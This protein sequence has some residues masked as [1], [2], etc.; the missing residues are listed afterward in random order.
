MWWASGINARV[1]NLE[2]NR[3]VSGVESARVNDKRDVQ[4]NSIATDIATLKANAENAKD[5]VGEIKRSI[6]A[7]T[8]QLLIQRRSDLDRTRTK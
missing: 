4:L 1:S 7:L 6:D 3:S 5:Q 8:Q 2:E